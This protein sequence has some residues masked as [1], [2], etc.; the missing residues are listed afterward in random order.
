MKAILAMILLAACATTSSSDRVVSDGVI[1]PSYMC[2]KRG[3]AAASKDPV[4]KRMVC[5]MEELLGTHMAR[6]VCRDEQQIADDREGSQQ[7]LRDA[8]QHKCVVSPGSAQ[9]GK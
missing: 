6:C 1:L 3:V 2:A 9:C 5:E 7:A 8:E 4:G